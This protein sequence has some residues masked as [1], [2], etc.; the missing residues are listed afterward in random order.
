M[1]NKGKD[2]T[3]VCVGWLGVIISLIII[4]LVT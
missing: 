2:D 1:Y 4:I 3:L